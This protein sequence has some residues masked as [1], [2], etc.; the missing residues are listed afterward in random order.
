VKNKSYK[1]QAGRRRTGR[2]WRWAVIGSVVG[3]IIVLGGVSG[4]YY[5]WL[6]AKVSAANDRVSQDVREALADD[7]T[8]VV[9]QTT[10]T[11]PGSPDAENI[12]LVGSDTRSGSGTTEGSRSDT[13]ILVHVDSANNFLGMLSFPRDLRVEVPGYGTR[14]LN[15][16][17][18]MGGPALTIQ[19]IQQTTGI[20]ID[21]YLE[22]DFT[23][24][25]EMTDKLGGVYVEVDRPY[26]YTGR[27]YANIDLD[28]GYQLLD[29]YNAL[30]Y[31]RYR[32][33]LNADFGRMERQQRY[34]N[35][36]RQQAMGWDLGLKLPGLV[37]AFFA[38]V[39]TD[40]G[41]NEFLRLAWWG[42]KL[43]GARIRQVSIRGMNQMSGGVTFVFWKPEQMAAAVQALL[44]PPGAAPAV[45]E[46]TT[47]SVA[48][49]TTTTARAPVLPVGATPDSIPNASIWKRVAQNAS[50]A[51]E[52][53]AYVPKGYRIST[54][55]KTYA[56]E[57]EIKVGGG[58]R[59][60]LL[61]LYQRVG[62]QRAGQV[63]L[64]EEYMNVTATPWLEAP[65]ASPGKPVTYKGTVFTVVGT[66]GKV[67]RV[68]WKR[69]GVLYWVSNTLSR[70]ASEAELLAM[71]ESMIP[72]PTQR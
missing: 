8:T 33:D 29:G 53:P 41:T 58:K 10:P 2:K 46:G 45:S 24:F 14:K 72:I 27:E 25:V 57:Y 47:V 67:E 23:A 49:T 50:F 34:L 66:A 61:M 52:A 18:A 26:F 6:D 31:V 51:V 9:G 42:I 38:H 1:V 35:A 40:L 17:F 60:A 28:P 21:H 22:V 4:G 71:A 7:P 65:V 19:T 54:R 5:L 44:T 30:S 15:Y 20:D 32:H 69:N 39:A 37:G 59:P 63:K 64:Q 68:W 43:D 56:Y 48:S 70:V 16:A 11:T 3:L 62:V 55:S 13:I 36:L 12:L